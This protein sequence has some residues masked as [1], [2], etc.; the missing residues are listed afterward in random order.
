MN[1][2][3]LGID[4]KLVETLKKQGIKVPTDIQVAAIGKLLEG[5][6]LIIN[7]AT[8]SGKTLAY[9]LPILQKIDPEMSVTQAL[10]VVPTRELALQIRDVAH[11]F[12]V[13]N[14][15]TSLAVYGGK[16]S[17]N[18]LKHL[19]KNPHII[20]ATPGRLMDFLAQNKLDFAHID[21][22]VIDEV[23]QLL[24]AGFRPEIEQIFMAIPGA[25]QTI[26]ASATI[27]SQ[28]NKLAHRY[29]F[30]PELCDLSK[31]VKGQMKPN[32]KQEIVLT[33]D[34]QKF[35]AL[36][37]VL[38]EDHPYMAIIFCRTK[39]RANELLAK[40][41]KYQLDADVIHSD[42][43][44]NKRERIL[45]TFKKGDLQYLI[46]TDV[47]ARGLDIDFIT[48][49]YNFDIPESLE[50]YIHRI[51]RTARGVADGTSLTF[52]CENDDDMFKTIKGKFATEL[53]DRDVKIGQNKAL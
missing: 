2:E 44:Q 31:T 46:A 45:K 5:R 53:I 29:A 49:I 52:V 18:Q 25:A 16:S 51:G 28:V 40:M 22:V 48:H 6:N 11:A 14:K 10:I 35:P 3:S 19:E 20:V 4:E 1:F 37:R 34:R 17:S 39:R 38:A 50:V 24:L 43:A 30:K 13:A 33:N 8:G 41:K 27:S 47:A 26:F 21:H 42:I 32:I 36:L 12:E 7:S 9:L 15:R 23:D